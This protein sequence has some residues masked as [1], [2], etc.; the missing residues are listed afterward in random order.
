MAHTRSP[1]R[2][3]EGLGMRM[4]NVESNAEYNG[5]EIK[6]KVVFAE[7]D[8]NFNY[9]TTSPVEAE[10]FEM[11]YMLY[12]GIVESES[13]KVNARVIDEELEYDLDFNDLE[14]RS[15]NTENTKYFMFQG[16][17]KISGPFLLI[18]GNSNVIKEIR[19]LYANMEGEAYE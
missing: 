6:I 2:Y 3:G 15:L 11:T 13:V 1:M 9:I 18:T 8:F 7:F 19:T 5:E 14:I 10:E 17:A 4:T 12:K 16:S